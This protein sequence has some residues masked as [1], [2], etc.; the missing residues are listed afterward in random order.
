MF[1]YNRDVKKM[2][3]KLNSKLRQSRPDLKYGIY[4]GHEIIPGL[5]GDELTEH[6]K[7]L[8]KTFQAKRQRLMAKGLVPK[9]GTPKFR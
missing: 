4:M 5:F 7:N 2:V 6:E 8:E 9:I 1:P 3:D